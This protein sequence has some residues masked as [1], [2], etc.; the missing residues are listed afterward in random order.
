VKILVFPVQSLKLEDHIKSLV[1]QLQ[2]STIFN[3]TVFFAQQWIK[4]CTAALILTFDNL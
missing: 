3:H 1:I 4:Q 2:I